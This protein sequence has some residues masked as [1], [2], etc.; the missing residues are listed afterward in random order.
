MNKSHTVQML[1][2]NSKLGYLLILEKQDTATEEQ[3]TATEES[4]SFL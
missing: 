2:A 1:L 4:Y 3:D